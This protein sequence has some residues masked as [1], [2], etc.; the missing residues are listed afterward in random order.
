MELKTERVD[1][2]PL[3]L[4]QVDRM[5]VSSLLDKHFQSHG[6][7]Q[8]LSLGI[9][10]SVWLTHILSEADHRMNHVESWASHRLE[11]LSRCVSEL[12]RSGDFSDDRLSLILKSLSND[13][14]WDSFE[15]DL[16]SHLLRVYDFSDE[17]IRLDSTSAAAYWQVSEDGLFQFGYSKDHRPD[18]P[19]V[20]I[21]LSTLDPLGLPIGCEVVSGEQADDRLYIP[22]VSKVRNTFAGKRGLLFIGDSKQAS[23]ETRGFINAGDDF[24]LCPLS[25]VQ[26]SDKELQRYLEPVWEGKEALQP[27]TRKNNA[28]EEESIAQ[29]YELT[30][31]ASHKLYGQWQERHL[32]VRS[33][34]MA[35]SGKI[36]LDKR[37]ERAIKTLDGLN[38]RKQGKKRYLSKAELQQDVAQ[39]LKGIA[40]LL[41]LSY[42]EIS[43]ER[44]IRG[45]KGKAAR[46]EKQWDI[47]VSSKIN[48][49]AYDAHVKKLGWRV[50]ACNMPGMPIEK[51]VLAY[52]EE[53]IIERSFKRMKGKALSLRPMYLQREDHV[54]GL[55]R[56]L[57]IALRVL[58]LIEYQLRKN[59]AAEHLE[60]AGLYAG[61][62]GRKTNRPTTEQVLKAFKYLDL[63]I[64][65]QNEQT[66]Y[67]LTQL[68]QLQSE[69][70]QL[71]GFSVLIYSKLAVEFQKPG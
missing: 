33:F 50:Y 23:S 27:I 44:E 69:I 5:E 11:S 63:T 55:I 17:P 40:P 39:A 16:G 56:L 7:W 19:Q 29:G 48:K 10:S 37:L 12:V 4:A 18:L 34:K 6:N 26:I 57:F 67:H 21:M 54:I 24:Y 47:F 70:L 64:I 59:L 46:V 42:E 52:R 14:C 51:A 38:K 28:G 71:L 22:A 60:L 3:L 9:V 35:E 49:D 58:V 43:S 1:D 62:P 68:N 36:T 61:N 25:K 53:F 31:Q 8:G 13:E 20:K 15:R 30:H 41:E 32:V 65:R 45:Y 66:I 2:I